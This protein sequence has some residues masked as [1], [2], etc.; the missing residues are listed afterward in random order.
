G[1]ISSYVEGAN[2]DDHRVEP[3]QL[4]R[5]QICTRQQGDLVAHLLERAW[6]IVAG[7]RQVADVAAV[8][9]EIERQR[10]GAR[11]GL[12]EL[13]RQVIVMDFDALLA[14]APAIDLYARAEPCSSHLGRRGHSEGE[15]CALS[16]SGEVERL[17]GRRDGPAG[18]RVELHG[19]G[20]ACAS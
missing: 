9:V 10:L 11:R 6:P 1:E 20:G 15:A 19:A 3:V 2:A 14:E 7:T 17:R 12:Q 18:R 8:N 4:V 5:R 16:G 13:E